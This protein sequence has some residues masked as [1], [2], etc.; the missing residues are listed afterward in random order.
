MIALGQTRETSTGEFRIGLEKR[1]KLEEQPAVKGQ[2]KERPVDED[3]HGEGA[4]T[5]SH[6]GSIA[7][8]SLQ[9]HG[10]QDGGR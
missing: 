1:A 2:E 7:R 9:E 5:Y 6:R 8:G 3:H 4:W 10:E